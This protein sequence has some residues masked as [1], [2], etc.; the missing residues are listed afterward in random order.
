MNEDIVAMLIIGGLIIG[1][2]YLFFTTRHRERMKLFDN[3]ADNPEAFPKDFFRADSLI[4]GLL[5]IGIAVG[6]LIG[7]A[8]YESNLMEEEIAYTSMIFLF[9]GLGLVTSYLILRKK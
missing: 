6:S 4:Y 7:Y 9:G 3:F 8:L 5:S 1:I 2:A